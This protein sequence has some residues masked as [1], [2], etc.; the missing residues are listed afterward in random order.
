MQNGSRKT[1]DISHHAAT[2]TLDELRAFLSSLR[3][4]RHAATSTIDAYERD[5]GQ[6]IAF[7]AQHLGDQISLKTLA[8][9][10]AAD[11][12]AF[13]TARRQDG[14]SS[15]SV[16]RGLSAIR[17]FFRHLERR[18]RAEA[19]TVIAMK[20]PRIPHSIPK[21]LSTTDSLRVVDA[22]THAITNTE[23]WIGTRNAA[24]LTLLYG[25]GLRISEALALNLQDAPLKDG[26]NMLRI[27]GKGGK[28]RLTPVLP[29]VKTAIQAYLDL[30]PYPLSGQSPLFVGVRGGR[31]S[32]RIIQLAIKHLRGTLGLPPTATPHALR[33]SFATHLLSAGG[34]LR[35]IQ[36]LLGHSSLS[37]TQIYTEVSAARLLEVY[38]KTHPRA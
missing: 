27:K 2:D 32:P 1:C 10:R 20:T 5:L 23:P 6:F 25:C 14:V 24:I 26:D 28:T 36:E 35:T 3:H 18:G 30:C 8:E 37:T 11:F 22:D 13:M 29:G 9:L 33:H 21:P 4:E 15:R 7:M 17:S 16:S 34:D 19:A 38:Q 31:L 12:R